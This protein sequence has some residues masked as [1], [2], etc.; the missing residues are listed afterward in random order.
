VVSLCA[1]NRLFA[2][3]ASGASASCS[4]WRRKAHC[5]SH[6]WAS[7]H[8]AL[9]VYVRNYKGEM[10]NGNHPRLP[11][12]ALFDKVYNVLKDTVRDYNSDDY[13]VCK[14]RLDYAA[15]AE[16]SA[17]ET[18]DELRVQDLGFFEDELARERVC[19]RVSLSVLICNGNFRL[20]A[21]VFKGKGNNG[22]SGFVSRL[23]HIFRTVNA[24]GQ[25]SK[26]RW[27]SESTVDNLW[28][29]KGEV[30]VSLAEALQSKL[31]LLEEG[32][33]IKVEPFKRFTDG[34]GSAGGARVPYQS[35]TQ[36]VENHCVPIFN[37]KG[38]ITWDTGSLNLPVYREASGVERKHELREDWSPRRGERRRQLERERELE[39]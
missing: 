18:D 23:K 25:D 31:V 17:A 19:G 9:R 26:Y 37:V 10:W 22:K 34:P 39:T 32:L 30:N 11:E 12:I 24:L 3:E 35:T 5:G 4:A 14:P 16:Q 1:G 28:H 6:S 38:K 33:K 8:S 2:S 27:V 15:W 21:L 36:S 20:K 29:N 7:D 13:F